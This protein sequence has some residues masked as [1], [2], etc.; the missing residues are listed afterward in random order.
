MYWL[1]GAGQLI[2]ENMLAAAIARADARTQQ[3]GLGAPAAFLNTDPS[4]CA[5]HVFHD[6]LA[7][8]MIWISDH[9]RPK[10]SERQS[11]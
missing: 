5:W 8:G 4:T 3:A 1:L 7:R 11:P 10:I 9:A 6:E 2:D